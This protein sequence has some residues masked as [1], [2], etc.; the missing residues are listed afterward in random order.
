MLDIFWKRL[1]MRQSLVRGHH[2][3]HLLM[4]AHGTLRISGAHDS[5]G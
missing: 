1:D 5:I 4:A 2:S 3:V